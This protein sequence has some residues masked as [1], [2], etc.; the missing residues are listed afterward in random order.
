MVLPLT[1]SRKAS[2]ESDQA[3]RHEVND[4][5][6]HFSRLSGLSPEDIDVL[7]DF[8]REE[9][10]LLIIRCPKRPARYFHG[11]VPPK[12]LRIKQKSDP[13]TG[14]VTT[15][16]GDVFVSDY[17]LMSVW[18]FL[19]DR[20]YE[21]IFFSALDPSTPTVLSAEAHSLLDKV[22]WRL[23]SPFQHGAQDDYISPKHPN[24]QLPGDKTERPDR[25]MAFNLGDR[26]YI[27]N[28]IELKTLYDRTLGEAAWPYDS[29]GHHLGERR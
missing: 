14:L 17:D 16:T 19:G 1:A 10:L 20:H 11:K 23:R 26:T 21:K 25:F 9:G 24:I 6:I 5:D 15:P 22:N 13:A 12:P 2:F 4:S 7:S 3:Q 8:S 27:C 29:K 18:R 28:G